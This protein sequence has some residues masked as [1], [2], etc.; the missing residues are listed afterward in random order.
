MR[1]HCPDIPFPL[2]A[3]ATCPALA[4]ADATAWGAVTAI[5][6]AWWA[7]GCAALPDDASGLSALARCSARQ[8]RR[9]HPVVRSALDELLP[10]LAAE[11][12]NGRRAAVKRSAA[13]SHAAKVRHSRT[14]RSE[15]RPVAEKP[16]SSPPAVRPGSTWSQMAE[17]ASR[18]QRQAA[19]AGGEKNVQRR[20]GLREVRR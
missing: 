14:V 19:S 3:L 6:S 1:A 12:A 7:S 8:W 13:A 4:M 16:I 2:G 5:V 10:G 17:A 20:G 11:Y 18:V 9:V 15:V